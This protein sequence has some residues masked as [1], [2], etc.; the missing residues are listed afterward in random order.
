MVSVIYMIKVWISLMKRV[1]SMKCRNSCV[2]CTTKGVSYHNYSRTVTWHYFCS[3]MNQ[4]VT[5][6][7]DCLAGFSLVDILDLAVQNDKKMKKG[8]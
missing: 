6:D 2:F 1:L 3:K 5:S 8:V 4:A 7:D